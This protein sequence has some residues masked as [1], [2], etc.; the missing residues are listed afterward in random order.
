MDQ[1]ANKGIKDIIN[2]FPGVARILEDYGIGCGP[3]T[4]GICRLKDILDIHR[5][6]KEAEGQLMRRIEVEIYPERGL[7]GKTLAAPQPVPAKEIR[8]SPPMQVLVDEH[9]LIKRWLAM[10]PAVAANL[11]LSSAA[12]RQVVEDGIDLI[13]CYADRLHHGKEEDI[14]FTCFDTSADI[15]QV[16]YDD[17]RQGRGLVQDMLR[18]LAT[19]DTEVLASSLRQYAAL[20]TEHIH[21]EDETLFPWLDGQ[22]TDTEKTELAA[23]FAEADRN[24]A[25]DTAKYRR[26]LERLELQGK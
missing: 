25:L 1:Y 11:D 24:L 17:H 13:R 20:L 15:F 3:C 18:A 16:V 6:D 10:I 22:L 19:K 2:Q 26:F 5:I 8:Y 21:K 4:V 23:R 9:T 14:L 12:G 7:A